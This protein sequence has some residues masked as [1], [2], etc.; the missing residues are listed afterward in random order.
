MCSDMIASWLASENNLDFLLK[1]G[2][3]EL[4]WTV[5]HTKKQ[6]A[7]S[8][9]VDYF[10]REVNYGGT[11]YSTPSARSRIQPSPDSVPPVKWEYENNQNAMRVKGILLGTLESVG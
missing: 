3:R 10:G 7:P 5:N 9:L 1:V 8:W 2:C 6:N 4:W 11:V